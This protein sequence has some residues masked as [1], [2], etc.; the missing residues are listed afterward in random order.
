LKASND[1]K[2]SP[3][4]YNPWDL[5]GS[6]GASDYENN[7]ATCN[8][9]KVDIGKPMTTEPGNMVGPTAQGTAARIA[10]DP[11]AYWDT[12]CNCVKGSAFGISPRVVIVPLYDPLYYAQGV[13]NGR[14]ASLKVANYLGFFVE[15]MQGNNVV[16]RITPVGGIIDR[17]AGPAPAG[18]FPR[19][20][21]L[22]Q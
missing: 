1:T 3:S 20:I 5:P 9:A 4:F 19:V 18:A 6:T 12:D 22:V 2:V 7:V 17:N 11:N 16:G 15:Q 8:P 13:Q 10:Q 21:R 14:N